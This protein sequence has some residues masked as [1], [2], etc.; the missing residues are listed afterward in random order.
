MEKGKPAGIACIQLDSEYKCKL[1]GLAERPSFCASFK[2]SQETCGYSRTEALRYL[3]ELEE[4]T[5]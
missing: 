5:R 4:L 3:E 1:F 2:A